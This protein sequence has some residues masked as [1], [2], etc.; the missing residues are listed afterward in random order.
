MRGV[1]VPSLSGV[2]ILSAVMLVERHSHEY[3]IWSTSILE[4]AKAGGAEVLA[5]EAVSE[6]LM[7]II[8]LSRD[9]ATHERLYPINVELEHLDTFEFMPKFAS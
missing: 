5:C 7:A 2:T 9:I 3:I 4:V 1:I 6:T 8:L